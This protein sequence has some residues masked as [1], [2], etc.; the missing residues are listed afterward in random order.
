MTRPKPN[1]RPLDRLQKFEPIAERVVRIHTAKARKVRV[2][3]DGLPSS[4]QPRHHL[5]EV[6]HD[7]TRMA[8]AGRPEIIFHAEVQFDIAG[9]EP[10][11]SAGC[12]HGRLGNL[13]HPE[14]V[15][16][17]SARNRFLTRRHG[18]LHVMKAVKGHTRSLVVALMPDST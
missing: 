15:D 16:E 4:G 14:Y 13:S 5:I 2:P 8:F 3:T 9:P 18:Q 10:G 6:R 11:A 7:H 12:K 1:R 17:K